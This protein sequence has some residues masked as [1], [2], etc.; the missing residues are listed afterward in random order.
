MRFSD[1]GRRCGYTL[2]ST[3]QFGRFLCTTLLNL[4]FRRRR[5]LHQY[6][7]KIINATTIKNFATIPILDDKTKNTTVKLKLIISID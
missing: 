1:L 2:V 5:K 3:K 7:H 4:P 6:F